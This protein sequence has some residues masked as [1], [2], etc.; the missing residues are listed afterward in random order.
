MR[1]A[2]N[3]LAR[4]LVDTTSNR[5]RVGYVPFAPRKKGDI[6]AAQRDPTGLDENTIWPGA[7]EIWDISVHPFKMVWLYDL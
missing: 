7:L 6:A 1:G 4:T 3:D 5:K 2:F